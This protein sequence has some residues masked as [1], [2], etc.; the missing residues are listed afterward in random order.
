MHVIGTS[1]AGA[2]R[3]MCVR[4]HLGGRVGESLPL[5][6]GRVC[7]IPLEHTR[8]SITAPTDTPA[9]GAARLRR[10]NGGGGAVTPLCA[11]VER[12]IDCY[13]R[14][15]W[16]RRLRRMRVERPSRSLPG[17]CDYVQTSKELLNSLGMHRKQRNPTPTWI[18]NTTMRHR[19]T[20]KGK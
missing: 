2:C 14:A 11:L 10:R 12:A 15:A 7:A 13:L 9:G 6:Q 1:I 4:A 17:S 16:R 8:L 18:A 3:V 19:R 20:M 5:S